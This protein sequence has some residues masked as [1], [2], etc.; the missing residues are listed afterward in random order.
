M[1][2]TR[3]VRLKKAAAISPPVRNKCHLGRVAFVQLRCDSSTDEKW[4]V[5]E[6]LNYHSINQSSFLNWD[7]EVEGRPDRNRFSC[8]NV[9]SFFHPFLIVKQ[10]FVKCLRSPGKIKL[11]LS[12]IWWKFFISCIHSSSLRR[13]RRI[14]GQMEETGGMTGNNGFEAVQ[15]M[16]SV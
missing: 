11:Q 12:Q 9:V 6:K 3:H 15:W 14:T 13:R 5:S 8:I 4:G 16:N 2:I 1:A 10:I 7:T